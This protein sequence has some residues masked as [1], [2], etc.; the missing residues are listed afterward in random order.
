MA[1]VRDLLLSYSADV[2]NPT[3]ARYRDKRDESPITRNS[4]EASVSY[5]HRLFLR[6]GFNWDII[7]LGRVKPL[8]IVLRGHVKL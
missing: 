6:R 1:T 2:I 3:S 5:L 8:V 7:I 4:F